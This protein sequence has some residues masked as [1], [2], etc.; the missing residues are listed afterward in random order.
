MLRYVE[1]S[2]KS[3]KEAII[4]LGAKNTFEG[5]SAEKMYITMKFGKDWDLVSQALY[6]VDDR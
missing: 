5:I 4:I 1:K 3:L 6:K 2:G